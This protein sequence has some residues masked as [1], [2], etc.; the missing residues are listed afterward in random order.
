MGIAR[1]KRYEEVWAEPMAKAAGTGPMTP[2]Q[3][4]SKMVGS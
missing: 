2:R 4:E 1:E 3:H